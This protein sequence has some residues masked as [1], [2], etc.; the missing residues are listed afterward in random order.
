MKPSLELTGYPDE[1]STWWWEQTLQKWH[2]HGEE[3]ILNLIRQEII[4]QSDRFNKSRK[5]DSQAYGVRDLSILAYGNFFF[6]RTWCAMHLALAEAHYFRA[7]KKPQKGPIRVLDIGSGSG[8]SS[9][10]TLHFLTNLN[11]ENSITLEAWDYSGKSLSFLKDIH[12]SHIQLWKNSKINTKRMNLCDGLPPI[13]KQRYDL[14]L[15][16]YSM[17]EILADY[18]MNERIDWLKKLTSFLSPSGFSII[19]E[20]A[21][22]EV[23]DDLHTLTASLASSQKDLYLH[24]P[25]FNNNACPLVAE[26]SSY[27]SHEVRKISETQTV[28]KINSP[29]RLETNQVKFG[30]SLL[31]KQEPRSFVQDSTTCR[32]VSPINKKKGTVY[33]IGIGA[34]GIEY[35]YEIQ[36]RVLQSD[37]TKILTKLERGD[38]LEIKDGIVGKDKNRIRIPSFESISW[39]FA[40]RWQKGN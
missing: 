17:N 24:A 12:R 1:L 19:V 6:P 15:M 36:R 30:F 3:K 21:Q 29:L 23:C 7:W 11:L 9:L 2:E 13:E 33:F 40:P 34:D 25:Y 27:H 16:G 31:S 8:A 39:P 10:S 18:E 38:I 28:A 5:F 14:V 20:P 22:K 26:N 32:L 4:K 35:R 37:E